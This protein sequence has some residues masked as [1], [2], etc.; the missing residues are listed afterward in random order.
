MKPGVMSRVDRFVISLFCRHL[1]EGQL[2]LSVGKKTHH[3]MRT[4]C[5]CGKSETVFAGTRAEWYAHH[6]YD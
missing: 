5:K 6:G 1:W 4:C 2:I 3:D